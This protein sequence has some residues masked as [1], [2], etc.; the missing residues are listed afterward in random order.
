[1]ISKGAVVVASTLVL[2]PALDLERLAPVRDG[3]RG[4]QRGI[5]QVGQGRVGAG[6]SRPAAPAVRD[7]SSLRMIGPRP[8]ARRIPAARRLWDD[9]IALLLEITAHATIRQVL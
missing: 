3:G 5:H 8:Q 1:M 2:D 4:D 9:M 7:I 6:S